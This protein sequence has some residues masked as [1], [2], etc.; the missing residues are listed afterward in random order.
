MLG[1]VE[2]DVYHLPKYA[3]LES[4][5]GNHEPAALY[6]VN[7]MGDE[8][9]VP[10]L[11]RSLPARLGLPDSWRDATVPYGYPAPIGSCRDAASMNEFL[12]QAAKVAQDNDVISLFLRWHPVWPRLSRRAIANEKIVD[13]GQTVFVDLTESIEDW[14]AQTRNELRYSVRRLAKLDY[15]VAIDD[16]SMLPEFH[17]VYQ[18][19]MGRVGANSRYC[20]CLDYI[21]GLREAWGECLHLASVV[22]PTGEIAAAALFSECHGI[23][24]YHLS[25]SDEKY[26]RLAPTKFLLDHMRYWG[27][28]RG[29]KVFHLG[30]G[31][32]GQEDS[33]FAFKA[34]FSKH[35]SS[36]QTSRIITDRNRYEQAMIASCG[37]P[38][39]SQEMFFPTYRKAA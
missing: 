10:L 34:A 14:H 36:F 3:S 5:Q 38:S 1:R 31:V 27:K 6:G 26:L 18:A 16:W 21:Y 9:L 7:H 15:E 17:R 28:E 24:Q 30:G 13:H 4:Q 39:H 11:L 19:T 2:H 22:S 12:H 35:R 32:D 25:G 37:K 23:L 33:L 29:D 20:Y 8:F